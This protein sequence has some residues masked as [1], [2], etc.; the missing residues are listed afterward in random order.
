M[1]S[2]RVSGEHVQKR[3]QEKA[4]NKGKG[5]FSSIK[6]FIN[7]RK[8]FA[9]WFFARVSRKTTVRRVSKIGF[10]KGQSSQE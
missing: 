6:K 8:A 7:D 10:H 4:A 1:T 2:R 3:K 5:K 9:G